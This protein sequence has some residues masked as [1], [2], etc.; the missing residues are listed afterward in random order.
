MHYLS[1]LCTSAQRLSISLLIPIFLLLSA[2]SSIPVTQ[3]YSSQTTLT[4]HATY[5]WLPPRMQKQPG[6]EALKQQHPFIAQR[7]EKAIVNNLLQRNAL[8][9]RHKPDAYISYNY[10]V[11]Q[12]Q[13][14]RP[15]SNIWFGFQSRHIGLGSEYPLDY[16]TETYEEAKWTID[17]YN[18]T[19]DLIWR[20]SAQRPVEKF[21]SPI[22]ADNYTQQTIDAILKQ[23]PPK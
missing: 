12:S 9:V 3:D 20:G 11:T 15:S 14:T 6:A 16:T 17:I 19:G 10:S 4:N 2:C 1:A 5:Q 23:Y 18:Q 13:V 8:I 21:S 22:E 7:I